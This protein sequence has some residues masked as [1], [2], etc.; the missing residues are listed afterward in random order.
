MEAWTTHRERDVAL[1]SRGAK[2]HFH[3]QILIE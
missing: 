3:G 2:P 1:E